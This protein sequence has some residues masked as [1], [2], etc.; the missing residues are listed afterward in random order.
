LP[1]APPKIGTGTAGFIERRLEPLFVGYRNGGLLQRRRS[2]CANAQEEGGA[3]CNDRETGT[4]PS[5]PPAHS[6]LELHV[7]SVPRNL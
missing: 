5:L 2:G 7:Y 4:N 6:R 1:E 3:T